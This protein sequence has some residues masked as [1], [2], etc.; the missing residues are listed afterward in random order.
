MVKKSKLLAA[1]DVH[2]GRN[3]ELERQKALQKKAEKKKRIQARSKSLENG[4]ADSSVVQNGRSGPQVEEESDSWVSD[5]S[6][7]PHTLAGVHKRIA[8]S[9]GEIERHRTKS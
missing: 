3:Y 9:S 4:N 5:V 2:K 8:F 6:T 1:L 7:G